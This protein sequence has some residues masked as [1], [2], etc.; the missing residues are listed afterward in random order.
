MK[1]TFKNSDIKHILGNN[2][3][4][5]NDEYYINKYKYTLYDINTNKLVS[6]SYSLFVFFKL[7]SKQPYSHNELKIIFQNNQ[8]NFDWNSLFEIIE[9]WNL[10]D[11]LVEFKNQINIPKRFYNVPLE[12]K[13]TVPV[14]N[15]PYDVEIHLTHSCNLKC[16]HCFQ[17][18]KPYDKKYNELNPQKWLD[19]FDQLEEMNTQSIRFS[20]GEPLYYKGFDYIINKIIGKRFAINILTNGLLI[21]DQNIDALSSPNVTLNISLDGHNA[22]MHEYLRGKGTFQKLIKNLK[23]L[24]ANNA[25]VRISSTLHKKNIPYIEE[26]VKLLIDVGIKSI[27]FILIEPAG[28]AVIN[29]ELLILDYD[30]QLANK[31]IAKCMENFGDKINIQTFDLITNSTFDISNFIMGDETNK[32]ESIIYCTAGTTQL[33]ICSDGILYPCIH[34]FGYKDL[35]IGDINSNKILNLWKQNNLWL[36]FRGNIKLKDINVCNSCEL[37]STCSLK[38]CRVKS[39]NENTGLLAKPFNCLKDRIT[40]N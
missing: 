9:K 40:L 32:P 3:I 23:K 38:N 36:N 25:D 22:E 15:T 16:I 34:A 2:W 21:N 35:I 18:S 26:L 6:I 27:G 24:A 29:K 37:V 1:N 33:T 12:Y 17:E 4:L 19:I 30:I 14:A 13:N 11:L 7:I 5:R 39:Y 31:I 20:G 10:E 28:R 8:I